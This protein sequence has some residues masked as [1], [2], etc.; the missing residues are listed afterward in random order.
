MTL[1]CQ[2]ENPMSLELE[3]MAKQHDRFSTKKEDSR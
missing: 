2:F 3:T 1:V